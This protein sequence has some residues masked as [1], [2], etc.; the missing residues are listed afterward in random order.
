MPDYNP[1]DVPI[2][3]DIIEK[4]LADNV[5]SDNAEIAIEDG[6]LEPD[7]TVI[8]AAEYDINQFLAES[9][10]KDTD[11]T[12]IADKEPQ[13]DDLNEDKNDAAI[14]DIA[15]VETIAQV[16]AEPIS[17]DLIVKD[18]VKQLMPDL[19]QQLKRL[20]QQ[21]LEEKLPEGIIKSTDTNKES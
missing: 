11:D 16:S 20:L 15:S 3:D 1:K 10:G 21:A 4:D 5:E 12:V 8:G 17:V 6:L 9:T 7:D 18:I 13:A 2:L 14:I 19:E